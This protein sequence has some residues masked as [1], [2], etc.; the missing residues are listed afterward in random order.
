MPSIGVALLESRVDVLPVRLEPVVVLLCARA[1]HEKTSDLST[2]WK[3]TSGHTR[4]TKEDRMREEQT[5]LLTFEAA[6]VQLGVSHRYIDRLTKSGR[7]EVIRLGR[8]RRV[9][10]SDIQALVASAPVHNVISAV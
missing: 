9:R 2:V 5:V 4:W 7:I 8:L 3:R 1:R 10:E 6:A